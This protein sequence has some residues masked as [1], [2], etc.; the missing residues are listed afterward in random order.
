MKK[1]LVTGCAGFIGSHVSEFLLKRGDL[2]VGI[3]NLNDYYDPTIK[4]KNVDLLNQYSNFTF[5]KGDMTNRTFVEQLLSE[6]DYD[7]IVHLASMAGV[8]NSLEQPNAYVS[9]NIDAFVSLLDSVVKNLNTIEQ[10]NSTKSPTPTPTHI[11]YASSS[12]VY[13]LN[14]PPFTETDTLDTVN[15]PYALS[16]K[17]MEEFAALYYR[18]YG[19]RTI[20]LRFFTVYGPRGRI[21][22]APYKFLK[23]IHDGTP[24]SQYGDGTSSRDYTYIDDIV[25]G[26][27]AS[28]DKAKDT[29]QHQI[30]NLGNCQGITLTEFIKM[31]EKVVKKKAIIKKIENQLGDVPVTLANIEKA[32]KELGYSPKMSLEEGLYKTY[33]SFFN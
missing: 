29:L 33:A 15:S 8:R 9:N 18:L 3:D 31:C 19:I 23:A 26:V 22:M 1:I 30:Y 28:I 20:G 7:V 21:D 14:A 27:I 11:V 12:S 24:I 10:L 6:V 25:S 16:K 17:V 5:E 13:G 4:Q 2:V 32:K